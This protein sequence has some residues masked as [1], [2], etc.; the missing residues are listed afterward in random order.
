MKQNVIWGV[1]AVFVLLV[2]VNF[3]L[4]GT[5]VT[6]RVIQQVGGVSSDS[7]HKFFGSN[8]TVGGTVLS[9][10]TS[11]A[12]YT[13]TRT[14]FEDKS[15]LKIT[16]NVDLVLSLDATSS[17]SSIPNIGDTL[18][19]YV[20]NASTTA[21]AGLTLAAKDDLLDLQK[22]EDSA[23]LKILGLDWAKLTYV[24]TALSGP[25]QVSV[26]FDEMTE[27]D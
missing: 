11:K 3:P 6:E 10:S 20:K 17:Y 21:A 13:I 9:T 25:G 27:A 24:R 12:T 2:G 4:N 22:N 16:P 1:V 8:V 14:E 7:S 23:D 18:V 19:V 26:L 5:S 15:L